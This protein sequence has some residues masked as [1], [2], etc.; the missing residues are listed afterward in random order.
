MAAGQ[1]AQTGARRRHSRC[2]QRVAPP[3]PAESPRVAT[4]RRPRVQRRPSRPSALWRAA[5][6]WARLAGSALPAV[7]MG[8]PSGAHRAPRPSHSQCRSLSC[9]ALRGCSGNSHRRGRAVRVRHKRGARHRTPAL[10]ADARAPRT[11]QPAAAVPA[12]VVQQQDR[13][14]RGRAA[15]GQSRT[16]SPRSRRTSR[17]TSTVRCGGASRKGCL[18]AERRPAAGS[19]ASAARA[20]GQRT[21]SRGVSTTVA[22]TTP[23]TATGSRTPA[24]SSAC[25][26]RGS[27]RA[28]CIL[29]EAC[30]RP[31]HDPRVC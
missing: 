4:L 14:G 12:G 21:T 18:V 1:R 5:A 25:L 11:R 3:W 15:A 16:R 20:S 19:A 17:A 6:W 29:G 24:A 23:A 31:V 7:R 13:S 10:G 27:A 22:R 9:P 26:R 8:A 30:S 2:C 28:A